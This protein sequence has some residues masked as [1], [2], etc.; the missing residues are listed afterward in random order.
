MLVLQPEHVSELSFPHCFVWHIHINWDSGPTFQ[1]LP[2]LL[3][4]LLFPAVPVLL[5]AV[6]LG[7]VYRRR[8][9]REALHAAAL[10]PQSKGK[11]IGAS[12][13]PY[14]SG[15]GELYQEFV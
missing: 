12:Y 3:L 9:H 14:H 11:Q 15:P 2:L 10:V 7:V 5:L 1:N 8:R 6:I 13:N 4:P